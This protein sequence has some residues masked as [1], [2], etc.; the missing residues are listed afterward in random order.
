[1]NQHTFVFLDV[2][3]TKVRTGDLATYLRG[4]LRVHG[5]ESIDTI[6]DTVLL[7]TA[8]A[9]DAVS[10]GLDAVAAFARHGTSSVRAGMSTGTAV[11][12][13]GHWSG[14]VLEVAADVARLAPRGQVLVTVSTRQATD[15]G[16]IDFVEIGDHA[17][18]G[19]P[20]PIT[21]YRARRVIDI[22]PSGQTGNDPARDLAIGAGRPGRGER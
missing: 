6:D 1:M 9:T 15:R 20:A 10:A 17:L 21:L 19:A 8:R 4:A 16:Q 3:G 7:Y 18:A 13:R 2:Q 11:R 14:P 22:G 12:D 5:G